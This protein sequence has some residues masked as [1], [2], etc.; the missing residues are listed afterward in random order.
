RSQRLRAREV[1]DRHVVTGGARRARLHR[2]VKGKPRLEVPDLG[3]QGRTHGPARP[4]HEDL[5]SYV[6]HG[7]L[8][9]PRAMSPESVLRTFG[10]TRKLWNFSRSS[11]LSTLPVAPIGMSSTL[12]TA[13]AARSGPV[14]V[15]YFLF[16]S[17]NI[18]L[19]SRPSLPSTPQANAIG[20]W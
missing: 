1:K 13:K 3:E 6:R 2:G 14:L 15:T 11:R 16:S 17:A 5:R 7:A 8:L 19:A 9:Y 20:T 4:G 12:S 18:R 10:S